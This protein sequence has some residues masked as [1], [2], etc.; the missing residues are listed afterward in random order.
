MKKGHSGMV[1]NT[2]NADARQE[3]GQKVRAAS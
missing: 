2:R 1:R 3:K